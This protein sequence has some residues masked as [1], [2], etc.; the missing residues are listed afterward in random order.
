MQDAMMEREGQI[1][2][3]QNTIDELSKAHEAAKEQQNKQVEDLLR[4]HKDEVSAIR[5]QHL[6]TQ[7]ENAKLKNELENIKELNRQLGEKNEI[8]LDTEAILTEDN[9]R[10]RT[11]PAQAL[12]FAN[13]EQ[14]L[15]LSQRVDN[16]KVELFQKE[17]ELKETKIRYDLLEK[18]FG[19]QRNLL[20]DE[21]ES[22]RDQ[23][24]LLK[25]QCETL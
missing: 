17:Q 15:S 10:L 24:E 16:I 22:L 7:T 25:G 9:E 20:E 21:I 4:E 8:M 3:L 14:L 5:E 13:Q 12:G 19:E 23:N 11:T 6:M 18:S 1:M 2:Q